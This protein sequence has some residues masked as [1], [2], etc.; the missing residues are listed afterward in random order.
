M[1]FWEKEG[2]KEGSIF[3]VV[4]SFLFWCFLEHKRNASLEST[5]EVFIILPLLTIPH[6]IEMQCRVLKSN[7]QGPADSRRT[8]ESLVFNFIFIIFIIELI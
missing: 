3:V 6:L 1:F 7:P 5:R 2:K 8:N 4:G